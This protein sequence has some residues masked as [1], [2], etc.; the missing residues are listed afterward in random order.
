MLFDY[1]A[2]GGLKRA[3]FLFVLSVAGG[4]V[5]GMLSACAYWSMTGF[6]PFVVG[7]A[8]GFLFSPLFVVA[9]LRK[10]I[11]IGPMI[12][13]GGSGIIAAVSS[14]FI[15]IPISFLSTI[16]VFLLLCIIVWFELQETW[17]DYESSKCPDC[18]YDLRGSGRAAGCPECGWNRSEGEG[19]NSETGEEEMT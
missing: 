8:V 10:N 6:I 15:S 17:P 5:L 2:R 1:S 13:L 9:T 19:K 11:L 4:G 12:I 18:G 16:A 7:L 14:Y 3:A